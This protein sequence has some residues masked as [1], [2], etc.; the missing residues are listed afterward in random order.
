MTSSTTSV[1]PTQLDYDGAHNTSN[2]TLGKETLMPLDPTMAG[3]TAPVA[4]LSESEVS[5]ISDNDVQ[6]SGSNSN[7][8]NNSKS[9]SR[10]NSIY[11]HNHCSNQKPL[12]V[13]NS[14]IVNDKEQYESQVVP[15]TKDI[16]LPNHSID[17]IK[18]LSI[19]I[20]GSLAKL[21]YITKDPANEN[22]V[23]LN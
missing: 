20:G 7:S 10:Q 18:E 16:S 4:L 3:S 12:N 6:P 2:T 14:H 21:V 5:S 13:S 15:E 9:S 8:N 11:R 1:P 22:G 17:D 19:D 23:R